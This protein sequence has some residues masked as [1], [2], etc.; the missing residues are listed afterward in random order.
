MKTRYSRQ[1]PIIGEEGQQKL[2]ESKVIVVGIGGLGC[3]VS[4][5]LNQAGVGSLTIIDS[6]KVDITNL[7]RQILFTEK[8]IG[9]SKVSSAQA[10]LKKRNSTITINS[11]DLKVDHYNAF[12]LCSNHDIIVDCSDNFQTKY[13]L[14]SVS[15]DLGIPLVTASIFQQEAYIST[16]N[17]SSGACLECIFPETPPLSLAPNCNQSGVLGVDAGIVGV[18]QAK[19]VINIITG[20]PKLHSKLLCLD[21]EFLEMTTRVI[22][23]KKNC[24]NKC[25]INKIVNNIVTD[26]NFEEYSYFLSQER[27]TQIID[28]RSKEEH[29]KYNIGGSNI[30]LAELE[31]HYTKLDPNIPTILYCSTGKRSSEAAQFLIKKNFNKI[32]CLKNGVN[33]CL[34]LDKLS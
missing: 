14:N 20:N 16:L 33:S 30:T 29:S 22:K 12:S 10:K 8:D 13:L 21:L 7:H 15:K 25:A 11:L 34:S 23:K 5:Y 9:L 26:I 6:D 1:S 28:C 24:N 31:V 3:P 27:D 18:I 32:F 2:S 4:L 17:Y 19:E